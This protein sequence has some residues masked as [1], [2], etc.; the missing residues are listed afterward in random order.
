M[1]NENGLLSF[2]HFPFEFWKS[3]ACP[4]HC[5]CSLALL[6]SQFWESEILIQVGHGRGHSELSFVFLE[7]LLFHIGGF[8]FRDPSFLPFSQFPLPCFHVFLWRRTSVNGGCAPLS[9]VDS[10]YMMYDVWI[11]NIN[12]ICFVNRNQNKYIC[13]CPHFQSFLWLVSMWWF[14]ISMEIVY[15]MY[16]VN[17]VNFICF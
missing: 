1:R 14:S 2:D 16:I 11:C 12:F 8:F 6:V 3:L 10:K 5:E 9:L 4:L 15:L 17:W 13:K 7:S